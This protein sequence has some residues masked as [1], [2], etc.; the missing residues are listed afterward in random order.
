[1]L[2]SELESSE[3]RKP[4][5]GEDLEEVR[6]NMDFGGELSCSSESWKVS[7]TCRY[8]GRGQILTTRVCISA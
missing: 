7:D 5:S 3:R 8:L 6:D 2:G 1:V 4:R